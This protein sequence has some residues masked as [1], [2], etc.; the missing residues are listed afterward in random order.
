MRVHSCV[1]VC[2]CADINASPSFS[3]QRDWEQ[4]PCS[5]GHAKARGLVSASPS[6]QTGARLGGRAG[7]GPGTLGRKQEAGSAPT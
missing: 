4:T 2:V 5:H 7:A 1:S 6:P 3:P